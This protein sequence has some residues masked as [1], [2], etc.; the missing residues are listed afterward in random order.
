MRFCLVVILGVALL[1]LGMPAVGQ[2]MMDADNGVTVSTLGEAVGAPDT[3]VVTLFAEAT[4]GNASDALQQ[5]TDKTAAATAGIEGLNLSGAVVAAKMITFAN[6]SSGDPFGLGGMNPPPTGTTVSQVITVKVPLARPVNRGALSSTISAILDAA[7]KVG[8]GLGSPSS[9]ERDFMGEPKVG[10]IQYVLEDATALR[11]AALK[12][13]FARTA[14]VR[15]QLGASGVKVGKLID[16]NYYQDDGPSEWMPF[17]D[18]SGS[19]A[20]PSPSSTSPETVYVHARLTCVY[21]LVEE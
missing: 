14:D 20:A 7:N 11:A 10:A 3:M 16:V 18:L 19:Q 12:D 8:V 15:A 17:S 9:A 13:A 4:S 1:G 5:C 6:A 2:G 21:A